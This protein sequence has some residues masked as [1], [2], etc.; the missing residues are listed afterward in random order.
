MAKYNESIAFSL[1]MFL[2]CL[3]AYI[4]FEILFLFVWMWVLKL[5][6]GLKSPPW[7]FFAGLLLFYRFEQ[8]V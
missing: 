7:N 8:S 1:S 2:T 5:S 4:D 6:F 3:S